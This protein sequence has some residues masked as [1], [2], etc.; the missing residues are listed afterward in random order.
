[1][2]LAELY[3]L[4][5]PYSYRARLT[6]PKYIVNASGD[7]FFLPDSSQFYYDDL[8]GEKQ[9]RYVPNADHSLRRSDAME[10]VIAFYSMIV[11]DVPRP[12][13]SWRFE[14]DDSI[15]VTARDNPAKVRLWQAA[16]PKARDFRVESLGRKYSDQL[17]QSKSNDGVYVG[18]V[19]KPEQ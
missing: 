19:K 12:K 7:Q 6:M 9:L 2:K 18:K 5:D 11:H 13:Y 14:G 8:Q 3:K 17:L 10:S 1:P 4:V 15:V 16:N